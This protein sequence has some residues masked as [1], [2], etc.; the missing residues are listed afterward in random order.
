MS[1][2]SLEFDLWGSDLK[3]LSGL[4]KNH[5]SMVF[6][7]VLRDQAFKLK[8]LSLSSDLIEQLKACATKLGKLAETLQGLI[9]KGKNKNKH[10]K[11]VMIEVAMFLFLLFFVVLFA[12]LFKL[13]L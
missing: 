4:Q 8:P 12:M 11:T 7:S 1:A 3:R 6:L 2:T 10:Y 13:W 5:W 9:H